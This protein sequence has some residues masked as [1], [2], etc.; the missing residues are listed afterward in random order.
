MNE[1]PRIQSWF[2]SYMGKGRCRETDRGSDT[3]MLSQLQSIKNVV[4][5]RLTEGKSLDFK[6]FVL[7]KVKLIVIPNDLSEVC[8][9]CP[10]IMAGASP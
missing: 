5:C 2:C 6:F 9:G 10:D 3:E 1:M 4:F 7:K 8:G